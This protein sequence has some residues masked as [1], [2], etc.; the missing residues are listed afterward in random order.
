M[1]IQDVPFKRAVCARLPPHAESEAR[2]F[3]APL[4]FRLSA[5]ASG[6]LN[7]SQ[8]GD[9]PERQRGPTRLDTIPSRSLRHA[10]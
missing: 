9:R 5:G 1:A 4:L 2:S 10:C 6:F 3:T 8:S 7:F